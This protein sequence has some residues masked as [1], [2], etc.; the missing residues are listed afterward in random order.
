MNL[1]VLSASLAVTSGFIFFMYDGV[2]IKYGYPI[3][4]LFLFHKKWFLII[5]WLMIIPGSIEFF[6]QTSF[7]VG[8]AIIFGCFITAMILIAIFKSNIQW[9]SLLMVIASIVIWIIGGNSFVTM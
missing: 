9:I 7:V 6:S 3:G 4:K 8:L 5:G 2:A 1:F